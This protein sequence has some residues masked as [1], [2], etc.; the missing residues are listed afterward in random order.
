MAS[1]HFQFTLGCMAFETEHR[2]RQKVVRSDSNESS[3]FFSC[4]FSTLNDLRFPL[5]DCF[6]KYLINDSLLPS[7]PCDPALKP[8]PSNNFFPRTSACI[9]H[10][11]AH[12]VLF[13]SLPFFLRKS[14]KSSFFFSPFFKPPETGE[15][16]EYSTPPCRTVSISPVPSS[17]WRTRPF[18]QPSSR[19]SCEAASEASPSAKF[20]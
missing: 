7:K 9:I 11:P 10:A 18:S 16:T 15:P 20:A 14:N 4:S 5:Y 2:L 17:A 6:R 3:V 8:W 13:A 12:D 19:Q 1:L